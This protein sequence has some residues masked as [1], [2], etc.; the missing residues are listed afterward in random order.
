MIQQSN[1][2]EAF[3]KGEAVVALLLDLKRAFEAVNRYILLKKLKCDSTR[4]DKKLP[5]RKETNGENCYRL[6]EEC[7]S[8]L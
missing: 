2:K 6:F 1:W 4:V 5:I 7:R 8:K 3:D